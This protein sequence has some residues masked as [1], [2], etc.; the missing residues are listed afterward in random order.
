[1]SVPGSAA[2]TP[3]DSPTDNYD[4][5]SRARAQRRRTPTATPGP[6]GALQGTTLPAS[7]PEAATRADADAA[8]RA[9]NEITGRTPE[10]SRPIT[11]SDARL[12]GIP[13]VS[14][15][16]ALIDLRSSPARS[17]ASLPSTIGNVS[18][19]DSLSDLAGV[20]YG[21]TLLARI[22]SSSIT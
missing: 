19:D 1:M 2:F 15:P 6:R 12:L 17:D 20:P 5:A 18:D 13:D 11:E 22:R 4:D 7:V 14:A 3:V 9:L 21:L 8:R 10:P 16:S